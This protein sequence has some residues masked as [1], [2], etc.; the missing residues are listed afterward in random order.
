MLFTDTKVQ[1]KA[2]KFG[3]GCKTV[4]EIDPWTAFETEQFYRQKLSDKI[5]A[6]KFEEQKLNEQTWAA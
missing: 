6:T 1:C 3:V 5:W 2:W 4:Y